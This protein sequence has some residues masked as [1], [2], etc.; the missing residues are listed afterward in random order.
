[1]KIPRKPPTLTAKTERD[2]VLAGLGPWTVLPGRAICEAFNT[3]DP[4]NIMRV[5]HALVSHADR[6]TRQTHCGQQRIATALGITRHTVGRNLR[7]LEQRGLIK[8]AYRMPP[9]KSLIVWLI[10]SNPQVAMQIPHTQALNRARRAP[11]AL[12]A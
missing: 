2:R 10:I 5:Y 9:P 12:A 8:R 1:M 3:G 6:T 11:V 7:K 4:I